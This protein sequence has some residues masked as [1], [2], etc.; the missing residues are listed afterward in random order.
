MA[1]K[2]YV[3]TSLSVRS[4]KD[5]PT[6]GAPW[7]RWLQHP[8]HCLGSFMQPRLHVGCGKLYRR[9]QGVSAGGDGNR[10]G[11]IIL[12]KQPAEPLLGS[13]FPLSIMYSWTNVNK[14]PMEISPA[15]QAVC[16]EQLFSRWH[17]G[18]SAPLSKQW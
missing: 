8:E 17:S 16:L 10:G 7:A 14:L 18:V 11:Q 5:N 3:L 15:E 6:P 4:F 13:V 2:A 9:L 12:S 1:P